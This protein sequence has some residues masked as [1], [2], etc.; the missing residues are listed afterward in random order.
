MKESVLAMCATPAYIST[1]P[2]ITKER[3]AVRFVARVTPAD[4]Q[5][6]AKAASLEGRSLSTFVL[7]HVREAA[8]QIIHQRNLIQLN[9]DQSRCFV[10]ALLA[11]PRPPTPT[12]LESIRAY[13]KSVK[14]DLD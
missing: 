13:R 2:T 8:R 7:V 6:F 12:M 3:K 9:A 1:V 5:L 10:E 11:T 14:S 4:K